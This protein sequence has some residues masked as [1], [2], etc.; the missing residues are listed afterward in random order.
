LKKDLTDLDILTHQIENQ[1]WKSQASITLLSECRLKTNQQLQVNK[2]QIFIHGESSST[3]GVGIVLNK[4]ATNAWKLA[5]S[6]P[7]ITNKGRIMGLHLEFNN[8]RKTTKFFIISIYLPCTGAIDHDFDTILDDVTQLIT[9]ECKKGIIPIIG[10]DFNARLGNRNHYSDH[11]AKC[12]GPHGID[13]DIN[14]RGRTVTNF[15]QEMNLCNPASFFIK[16]NYST[17][18]SKNTKKE[19]TNKYHTFDYIL[20][21]YLDFKF[22]IRDSTAIIDK[23][24]PSTDHYLVKMTLTLR[25]NNKPTPNKNTKLKP[26]TPSNNNNTPIKLSTPKSSNRR[27]FLSNNSDATT[28][29][30]QQ[31]NDSIKAYKASNNNTH[32]T[33]DILTPI[34]QSS[35]STFPSI[36]ANN[37]DWFNQD[38][39]NLL[40]LISLK[41]ESEQ[42]YHQDPTNP[43]TIASIRDVRIKVKE[44]IKDAK[45]E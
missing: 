10:G 33:Q 5:G 1:S 27:N 2:H 3:G 8:G 29:Y 37:K 12:L 44:A 7:P 24:L 20:I 19:T 26:P 22:L 23:L 14:D 11:V 30:N 4:H 9:Q 15:L 35:S 28:A 41:K 21:P 34:L 17:W 40:T 42:K 32:L 31:V 45:E 39:T 16:N 36:Q 13:Q 6:Q 43:T 25:H 38:A 18:I